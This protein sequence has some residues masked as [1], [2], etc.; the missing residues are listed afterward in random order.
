MEIIMLFALAGL[1][2]YGLIANNSILF[3]FGP[4]TPSS[5]VN[6]LSDFPTK[7]SIDQNEDG[8]IQD[9]L[10]KY[11]F[12]LIIDIS[13]QP[14]LY[15]LIDSIA[16]SFNTIY[17]TL[18][19]PDEYYSPWRFYLH[20]SASQQS[21]AIKL[22]ILNL[23]VESFVILSSINKS[24]LEI[25]DRL[26]ETSKNN[27]LSYL[28]YSEDLSQIVSD[29]IIGKMVKANGYKSIVGIDQADS[30][31][32]IQTSIQNK[33]MNR[34][35]T[36]IISSSKAIYSTTIEGSLIV[37]E[38]GLEFCSSPESYE[39]GA[40]KKGISAINSA[41]LSKPYLE[42]D[43]NAIKTVSLE[44]FP[45]HIPI[46]LYSLVNIINSQKVII[47]KIENEVNITDTI[48][49]VGNTTNRFSFNKTK[50]VLSIAN[51]THELYNLGQFT[52]FSYQYQASIYSAQ[53][54]N[55]LNEIPGFELTFFPT[56]CGIF[57]YNDSIFMDYFA[58]IVKNMG[59]AY[60]SYPWAAPAYGAL[61][62]FQKLKKYLPQISSFSQYS[63]LD[64]KTEFP[65]FLKL[66]ASNSD[67]YTSTIIFLISL[68]FTDV[69][70]LQSNNPG[71]QSYYDDLIYYLNI[72]GIKVV[73]PPDKR[74]LPANYT[75]DKF[76]KYKS[77][78][79][80]AKDTNCR[81]YI[82][83]NQDHLA[84][85][86]GLYD[87]G[88]RRGDVVGFI[89]A[90][91]L[92]IYSTLN[93][94]DAL[95]VAEF[96][97]GSL[98][99][100]FREWVGALGQEIGTELSK[101]YS[102]ILY[103]CLT[104]DQVSVV[105]EAIIYMLARGQDYEDSKLLST[106]IRN[107]KI[108]SCLGN[109]YFD[110]E[111]NSRSSVQFSYHQFN[112]N[113]TTGDLYFTEVAIIDK[114]SN[115]IINFISEFRWSTGTSIPTNYRPYNRCPFD[116][117][118]VIESNKGK[119][120]LIII[121]L[122]F[123]LVAI[124]S[125]Y[126][127]K[128][129][130]R[131]LFKELKEKQILSLSD[132]VFNSYFFFQFCQLLS[133]GPSQ[134]SLKYLA[135]DL[136]YLIG[137]DFVY[138]FNLYFNGFWVVIYCFVA[139]SFTWSI[140]CS[141]VIL[142]DGFPVKKSI[143][144]KDLVFPILGHVCFMPVF[145]ELM[146]IYSC[147]QG[148]DNNLTD[149]FMDYD[150][151]LLCYTDKHL[152]IVLTGGISI[153]LYLITAIYLR[154]VWEFLQ[155]SLH[156]CTKSSYLS[157]LSLFQVLAVI[158]SKNLKYCSETTQGLAL[159]GLIF[160]MIVYTGFS[161]PYNLKS[162]KILQIMSLSAAFWGILTTCI[163]NNTVNLQIWLILEFSGFILISLIGTIITFRYPTLISD[164][165]GIRIEILFLFQFTAD[166]E[167]LQRIKYSINNSTEPTCANEMGSVNRKNILRLHPRTSLD[168]L[169]N[170]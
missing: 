159:C 137:L 127:S 150:C 3:L 140:I 102:S 57:Y 8:S 72:S 5:L 4:N 153:V 23:K 90:S 71:F 126:Q 164:E 44:L 135:N 45:N 16:S 95:K 114:Y 42:F 103:M 165:K 93:T 94:E 56:D 58:P 158:L 122:G 134:K 144:L 98:I 131:N 40:I 109:V 31:M 111:S 121:S 146:N 169:P 10:K 166:I 35:G 113:S 139:Y 70:I 119:L 76:D 92:Q 125:S 124:V 156:I 9:I 14:S 163:F 145:S 105:K 20:N 18:N 120:A 62:T 123:F 129:K 19:P 30:W 167:I 49:Y 118:L 33:N 50:I 77:Y 17:F 88:L 27:V 43:L 47:G 52:L 104:Y 1:G 128:S 117:Y 68:S 73:N 2:S 75:K 143:L 22:S 59:V 155:S 61:K 66:S 55:N 154:P 138:Y 36:F 32:K 112:Q 65:E 37:V 107:N 12:S 81:V 148:I 136:H 147:G 106:T 99:Y 60:L 91:A 160:V 28:K 53:R 26:Y 115:Q 130:F 78:F 11:E 34:P 6:L 161:N 29:G 51:G 85:Y 142:L 54:S 67:Y 46:P 83:T 79:Q 162:V 38:S 15:I 24:N 74:L 48:Y 82:I 97:P 39:L 101:M 151:T 149:S 64:D 170:Q 133:L 69:V 7:L 152:I 13:F 110:P 80:A 132:M 141:L 63:P 41:L 25:A 100:S 89:Q 87:I 157:V 86:Q 21:N 84:I 116:T 108:T 168:S 96:M